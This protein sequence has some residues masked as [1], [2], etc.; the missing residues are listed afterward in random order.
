MP[1]RSAAALL[2]TIHYAPI[3]SHYNQEQC[4]R[5]D[6]ESWLYMIVEM[7]SGPLPWANLEPL[8]QHKMIAESKKFVRVGGRAK[9]FEKCPPGYDEIMDIIDNTR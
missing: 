8:K 1:S 6:L 5:D 3:A 2:G 7:A 4:R 9:F